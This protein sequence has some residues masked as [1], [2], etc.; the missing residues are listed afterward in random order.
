MFRVNV[1]LLSHKINYINQKEQPY[2]S[3]SIYK[4]LARSMLNFTN[5]RYHFLLFLLPGILYSYLP[6]ILLPVYAEE[7]SG[8]GYIIKMG[9]VN[10]VGGAISSPSYKLNTSVGQTTSGDFEITGYRIRSGFQYS[11]IGNEPFSFSLGDD[12]IDLGT[13]IAN[14]FA[15][16]KTTLTVSGA[17]THGYTV[18]T[19]ENHPLQIGESPSTIPDTVC[20]PKEKCTANHAAPWTST[21]SYGFGYNLSG[22]DVD[23]TEFADQTFFRPFAN[24]QLNQTPVTLI[25]NPKPAKKATATIIFQ[26]NI[27]PTQG[28]GPYENSIQFIALPSY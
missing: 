15:R 7:L 20:D 9:T 3:I 22:D 11:R 16:T 28:N 17:G 23:K 26:A 12:S 1:R 8:S 14:T 4:Q 19:I 25:S 13:V 18:K 5:R 6:G 21:A 27:S 2:S 10:I 24:S